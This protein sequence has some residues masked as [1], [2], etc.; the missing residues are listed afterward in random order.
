MQVIEYLAEPNAALDQLARVL[1]PGGRLVIMSGGARAA[2][3]L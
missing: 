2:T 3:G 1:R